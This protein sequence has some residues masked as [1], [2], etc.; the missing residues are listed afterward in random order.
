MQYPPNPIPQRLGTLG[1]PQAEAGL[2]RAWLALAATEPGFDWRLGQEPPFDAVLADGAHLSLRSVGLPLQ[3]ERLCIL[4][5]TSAELPAGATLLERPLRQE[6]LMGWLTSL[7]SAAPAMP[8]MQVGPSANTATGAI[9]GLADTA[10][11]RWK[12]RRWPPQQLLRDSRSRMRMASLLSRR[13]LSAQELAHLS[14]GD[15]ADCQVF[16]QMLQGFDLVD[17]VARPPAATAPA[18]AGNAP[19]RGLGD[20]GSALSRVVRGLR[21]RLGLA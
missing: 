12:L 18:P 11:A 5:Q 17:R 4:G 20:S 15:P 8:A 1:L 10:S 6:A 16:L 7:S 19:A 13:A 21:L 14:G 2:V 3:G 9:A